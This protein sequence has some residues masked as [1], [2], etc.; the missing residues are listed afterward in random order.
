MSTG[1]SCPTAIGSRGRAI[2]I[3]E[4]CIDAAL[5]SR[6]SGRGHRHASGGTA[7]TRRPISALPTRSRAF[8]TIAVSAIT[9]LTRR[10]HLR[11]RGR[12]P[13]I[14]TDSMTA[15][16]T[17]GAVGSAVISRMFSSS[18]FLAGICG[19]RSRL[20][21]RPPRPIS[22]KGAETLGRLLQGAPIA[23]RLG[24]TA[25]R[26]ITALGPKMHSYSL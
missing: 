23:I 18:S 16:S 6:L 19:G 17:I 24:G 7:I 14:C 5:I 21:R 15:F 9:F 10:L 26:I 12:R 13:P 1:H 4:I 3:Q 11:R 22:Q 25:A 8:S 20:L 2:I